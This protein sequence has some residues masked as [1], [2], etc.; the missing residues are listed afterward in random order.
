MTS[1]SQEIALRHAMHKTMPKY[2]T[3]SKKKPQSLI[4]RTAQTI[5]LGVWLHMMRKT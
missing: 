3:M 4:R 5:T 1:E 2:I